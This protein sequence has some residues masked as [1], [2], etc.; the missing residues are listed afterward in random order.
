M[1]TGKTIAL[2]RWTVDKEMSLLFNM[3]SSMVITFLPRSMRLLISWLQS[4]SAVMVKSQPLFPLF[5]HLFAM[6]RSLVFPMLLLS[7]ISLHCSL[8]K[9][10]LSLLATPWKPRQ[11]IKK[12]RHYFVNKGLSSQGYGFSSGH[13]WM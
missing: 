11:H 7:S 6:K 1:N 4:P 8:K 9:A 5:P 12:Q 13:I 2:T 3:L 10:F